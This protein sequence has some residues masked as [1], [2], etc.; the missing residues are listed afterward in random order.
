VE[1]LRSTAGNF[2]AAEWVSL[3]ETQI[4]A[5]RVNHLAQMMPFLRAFRRPLN[6]LLGKFGNDKE[7]LLQVRP[8]LAA[9]LKF[10]AN[11]AISAL[12]WLP[13]AA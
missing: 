1:Q 5:G 13:I 9:D 6:H 2:I 10:C 8:E 7:I 12:H 3:E 11:P 4:I